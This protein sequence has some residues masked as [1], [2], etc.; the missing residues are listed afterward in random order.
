MH[1]LQG[2]LICTLLV[3]FVVLIVPWRLVLLAEALKRQSRYTRQMYTPSSDHGHVIV[4][5]EVTRRDG[6]DTGARPGRLVRG[7]R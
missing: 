1:T 7:R 3:V 2:Y 4:A 6:V 5:G